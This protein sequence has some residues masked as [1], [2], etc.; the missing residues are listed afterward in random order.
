MMTYRDAEHNMGLR[1]AAEAQQRKVNKPKV[2]YVVLRGAKEDDPILGVYS[3]AV[4][5]ACHR[6]TAI[7]NKQRGTVQYR[8]QREL[9][10]EWEGGQ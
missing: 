4:D 9:V 6:D 2:V 5:A 3:D 1:A 8:V 10:R 7:A